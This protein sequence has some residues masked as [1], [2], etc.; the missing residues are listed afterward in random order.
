ML[1][2]DKQ[3]TKCSANSKR[4]HLVVT[5]GLAFVFVLSFRLGLELLFMSA[6]AEELWGHFMTLIYCISLQKWQWSLRERRGHF[7]TLIEIGMHPIDCFSGSHVFKGR[8]WNI[9]YYRLVFSWRPQIWKS[10]R[11]LVDDVKKLYQKACRTCS[12]IIFLPSF[13]QSFYCF[14]LALLLIICRWLFIS[15]LML[16][17]KT[18]MEK[19]Q[20]V[21]DMKMNV[22]FSVFFTF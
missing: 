15:S 7:A 22:H 10:R 9:Y 6:W 2:F 4:N 3:H 21:G 14:L 13:N 11:R 20:T 8:Q 17:L 16:T 12:T 18:S 19:K 5:L 1:S